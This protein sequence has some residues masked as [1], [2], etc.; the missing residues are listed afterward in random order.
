MQACN[1]T[2]ASSSASEAIDDDAAGLHL[3]LFR[4]YLDARGAAD[5]WSQV[6]SN[7]AWYRVKY[8]SE[9]FGKECETPCYTAFYGGFERF[10]P[11]VPIPAW[12]EPLVE[13]VSST[14]QHPRFNA[15]LL[16]LYYD[17]ED[18]IAWHTDGRTFLGPTPT[19]ASLSLGASAQFMLRRMTDVWPKPGSGDNGIDVATPTRSYLLGDGDLL[20]MRRE[21]QAHWHH[22]VPK[23]RSRRPRIN[24]N[25]RYIQPG[26]ADAERGQQTYYK[27]M[28]HGDSANIVHGDAAMGMG[29]T[30]FHALLKRKGSLLGWGC[31]PASEATSA[32][33]TSSSAATSASS[34]AA[35]V[36]SAAGEPDAEPEWICAVCTLRNPPLTLVCSACGFSPTSG[37]GFGFLAAARRATEAEMAA[38]ARVGPAGAAAKRSAAAQGPDATAGDAAGESKRAAVAR[39]W[40]LNEK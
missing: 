5:L 31:Q 38:A 24:L 13:R 11:Y 37:S 23:A 26:S 30:T 8:K 3:L 14:L 4:K 28:V 34:S 21:T 40:R 12:L 18:E 32:A 20:V 10:A 33:A 22:R 6:V 1:A 17:G 9:R 7:T 35:P 16:R 39:L 25:F 19:I 2:A 27:Y 15:I 36:S 29:S